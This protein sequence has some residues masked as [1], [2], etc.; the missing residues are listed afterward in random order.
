[1]QKVRYWT[2]QNEMRDVMEQVSKGAV[3]RILDSANEGRESRWAR[4]APW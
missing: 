1:M 4:V 2:V 3:G